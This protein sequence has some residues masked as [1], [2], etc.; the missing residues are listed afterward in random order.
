[1]SLVFYCTV[2]QVRVQSV[3]QVYS[4]A[5]WCMLYGNRLTSFFCVFFFLHKHCFKAHSVFQHQSRQ[6]QGELIL[7]R[8]ILIDKLP[9]PHKNTPLSLDP[10]FVR[11]ELWL[12]AS[13]AHVRPV[14]VWCSFAAWASNVMLHYDLSMPVYHRCCQQVDG[15]STRTLCCPSFFHVTCVSF[16][17]FFGYAE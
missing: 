3:I 5:Y 16:V 12:Y 15:V 7:D 14:V 2:I 4:P 8:S 17:K 9:F 10:W 13:I 11:F 1:M 6:V